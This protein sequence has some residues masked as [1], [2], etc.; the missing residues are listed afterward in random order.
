MIKQNYEANPYLF[1][2]AVREARNV[3]DH[4]LVRTLIALGEL[5][6]PIKDEDFPVV[7][8]FEHKH[9]LKVRSLMEQHLFYLQSRQQ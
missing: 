2:I 6:Y 1:W 5:D 3:R 8:R 9:I 7:H 4:L